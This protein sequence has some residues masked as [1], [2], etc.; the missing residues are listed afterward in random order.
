M[1]R[2]VLLGVL[3]AACS[4]Q[5]DVREAPHAVRAAFTSAG[6]EL[7]DFSF[8]GSLV[9]TTSDSTEIDRLVQAQLMFS[10]GQLNGDSSVGRVD[11]ADYGVPRVLALPT[12]PPTYEVHYSAT[13]PVAW[14][15][16]ATPSSYAFVL[17]KRVGD[18]DQ[19]AFASKYGG[20]CTDPEGGTV[21]A[22]DMFLF[23]RPRQ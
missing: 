9:T 23:Y 5:G 17:P 12:T 21:G 10:I 18:D 2:A 1:R 6:A 22:G 11:E 3:L 14:G 20:A 16:G 19:A 15:G 13:L 7:V 4:P 8:D